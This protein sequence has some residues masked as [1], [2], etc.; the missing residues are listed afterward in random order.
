MSALASVPD[1]VKKEAL[2]EIRKF[3]S[4]HAII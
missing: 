2:Q 3:L 1:E 4:D